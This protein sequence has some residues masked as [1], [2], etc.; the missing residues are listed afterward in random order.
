[1]IYNNYFRKTIEAYKVINIRVLKIK[2][3]I[4]LNINYFRKNHFQKLD[5]KRDIFNN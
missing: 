5:Y 3:K 2:I 4:F 1:M